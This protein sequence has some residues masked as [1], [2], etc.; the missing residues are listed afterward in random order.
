M[1]LPPEIESALV[2]ARAA[3]KD[4]KIVQLNR[5]VIQTRKGAPYSKER[6]N[7]MWIDALAAA[8]IAIDVTTR[9]IPRYAR[10]AVEKLGYPVEKVARRSRR[11]QL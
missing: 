8:G 6:L 11:P 3:R 4:Q 2:R 1:K 10:S 9:D 5:Y 7:S